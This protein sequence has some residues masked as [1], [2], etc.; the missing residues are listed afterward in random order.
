M[1]H[2]HTKK[3]VV[4]WEHELRVAAAAVVAAVKAADKV[5]AEQK[6]SPAAAKALEEYLVAMLA[7]V[8]ACTA[9]LAGAED[10]EHALTICSSPKPVRASFQAKAGGK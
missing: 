8:N 9:A 10:G 6:G 2:K 7:A 4:L 5:A 3:I 1:A